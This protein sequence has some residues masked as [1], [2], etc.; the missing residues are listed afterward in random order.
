ML[1]K[2]PLYL[3]YRTEDWNTRNVNAVLK[4]QVFADPFMEKWR[5]RMNKGR[6]ACN[7][8]ANRIAGIKDD[9][10]KRGVTLKYVP[11]MFVVARD[12]EFIKWLTKRRMLLLEKT[13]R[14]HYVQYKSEI[15]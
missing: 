3:D 4:P 8:P 15:A 9:R 13:F 7:K 2:L 14:K 11:P 6:I 5:S 1:A 12:P 10:D